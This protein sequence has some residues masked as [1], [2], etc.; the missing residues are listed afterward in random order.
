MWG[1]ESGKSLE[2]LCAF[3]VLEKIS[4]MDV[5]IWDFSSLRKRGERKWDDLYSSGIVM[6]MLG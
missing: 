2:V 1:H 4:V 5:L 3:L 6:Y